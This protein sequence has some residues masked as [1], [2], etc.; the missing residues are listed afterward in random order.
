MQTLSTA[1]SR[2]A[3]IS[4]GVALVGEEVGAV[5]VGALASFRGGVGNKLSGETRGA[6]EGEAVGVVLSMSES[7]P[8]TSFRVRKRKESDN[9]WV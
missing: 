5:R 7:I 9:S 4:W 8:M 6:L 2:L 1:A 3:S